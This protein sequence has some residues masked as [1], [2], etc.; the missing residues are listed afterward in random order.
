[1][2]LIRVV[3]MSLQVSGGR[4]LLPE[5]RVVIYLQFWEQCSLSRRLFRTFD[6]HAFFYFCLVG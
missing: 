4:S 3:E 5:T 6:R 2:F 1:M